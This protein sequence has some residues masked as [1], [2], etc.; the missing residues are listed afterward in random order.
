MKKKI[1]IVVMTGIL[2]F[3]AT[4]C[5]SINPINAVTGDT[6]IYDVTVEKDE[7]E[8]L[9]VKL[10]MSAGKMYVS[11]G[12]DD[13]MEGE[14]EYSG[15][16]FKP[17]L[18]YEISGDKGIIEIDQK[19]KGVNL[20]EQKNEWD[21]SLSEEVPL[22]LEVKAGASDTNLDL[23]GLKLK[24]LTVEA[25]VGDIEVDL[26]GDWE[27]S[28]QVTLETGVG[29]TTVILPKDVG[30]KVI[31]KKGIGSTDIE[32]F[33]SK[34]DHTYVNEAYEKAE[35]VITVNAE[36]GVGEANFKMK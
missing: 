7:A 22:E 27:E 34:G 23:R 3:L 13:W 26:S 4:G 24:E 18:E 14:I 5:N 19:N 33:I 21:I 8:E 25:G 31:T 30:V 28:F 1:A 32:G 15:S 10:E 20:G 2:L 17:N 12:A 11:S 9:D 36:L 35:V 16:K 29:E 6:D